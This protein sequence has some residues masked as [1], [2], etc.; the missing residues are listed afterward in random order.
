[1]RSELNFKV[2]DKGTC[3]VIEG[4][5]FSTRAEVRTSGCSG[6]KHSSATS[7]LYLYPISKVVPD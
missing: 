4:P 7:D 3:V 2:H 5:R 1:M 6:E